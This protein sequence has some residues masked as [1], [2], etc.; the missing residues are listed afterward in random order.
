MSAPNRNPTTIP[1]DLLSNN[2]TWADRLRT[3]DPEFFQKL[4][5]QQA[6]QYFWIGCSDS[7]VPATQITGLLPGEMFVHRNVANV[8]PPADLNS[9]SALQFAVDVLKVRHVIVCGHYGCAGVGAVLHGDRL[10]LVDHWLQ[11]VE[12]V[13][14]KHADELGALKDVSRQLDRLCELNVMEQVGSVCRATSVQDAWAR[15]QPLAV[16]GWIYT[17]KDGLLRDLSLSVN[18]PSGPALG[19][20]QSDLIRG[21]AVATGEIPAG[22]V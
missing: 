6:P 21:A 15:G 9:L 22:D 17:V 20:P 11:N 5:H 1:I 16:H 3:E 14:Q 13:R 2:R 19:R 18:G 8:M 10:G 12:D 4:S 7:R